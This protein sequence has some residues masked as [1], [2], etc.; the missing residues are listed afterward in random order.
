[1]K[2]SALAS[3]S[4]GNCFYIE[5]KNSGILI[6]A[7]I[8]SKQIIERLGLLNTNPERIKGIFITHEHSDHTRGADVFARRFNIPVFA[9]HKTAE[10]CFLAEENLNIIKN[11]E[12]VNIAGMRIEAFSKSHKAE[13]P[14]S[15]NI[16]NGRKIS[17]MTDM[18][19][20]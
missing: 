15:Y 17:I 3:G 9:T 8:S 6:D 16:I 12:A 1:M 13:D 7:G 10:K 2:F 11:N 4:S 19:Y 14:V 20:A 18:G 5:N